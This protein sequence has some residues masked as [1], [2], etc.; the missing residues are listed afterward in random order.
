MRRYAF[1]I[2]NLADEYKIKY[3]YINLISTTLPEIDNSKTEDPA[4]TTADGVM[5]R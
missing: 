5:E 2:Y 4:T 3:F 1:Q